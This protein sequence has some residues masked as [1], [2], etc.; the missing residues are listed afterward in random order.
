MSHYFSPTVIV[1]PLPI[2]DISAYEMFLLKEFFQFDIQG[3]DLIYFFS[4]EGPFDDKEIDLQRLEEVLGPYNENGKGLEHD[5]WTS[6]YK[7]F[8]VSNDHIDLEFDEEMLIEILENIIEHSNTVK[9][10]DVVQS[11]MCDQMLMDG[12]GGKRISI[13]S[14]EIDTIDTN[15]LADDAIVVE[16]D[17]Q[18]L[19]AIID[20]AT[21]TVDM[22]RC[23][24]GF[25]EAIRNVTN[26]PYPDPEMDLINERFEKS[27][28]N[29]FVL[30]LGK[31]V[32]DDDSSSFTLKVN[33]IGEQS[34][35]DENSV[36]VGDVVDLPNGK[37]GTVMES[38]AIQIESL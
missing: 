24:N 21:L 18:L 2:S 3:E 34:D 36:N 22:H 15:D 7:K 12:F 38:H 17:N 20:L 33:V 26:T 23:M 11:Y 13:T 35:V 1:P 27:G 6:L 5:I 19:D 14:K 16:K 9:R 10:I 31:D 8:S 37:K 29:E 25:A 32:S 28:L 4:K 30:N